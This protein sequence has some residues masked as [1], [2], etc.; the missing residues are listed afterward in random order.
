MIRRDYILRMVEQFM[1][2]LR[3]IQRSKKDQ[4]WDDAGTALDEEFKRLI[5]Q[6]AAGANALSLTELLSRLI[7]GEP[8]QAV[9][10]KTFMLATLLQ[11]AGDLAIANNQ[12]EL[13]RSHYLKGL[14]L[15]LHTLAGGDVEDFPEFVPKVEMFVTALADFELPVET[16]AALMQHYERSGEFAKAEDALFNMLEQADD[17][18]RILEFGMAFYER[19]LVQSDANLEAGNL[20]RPEAESSLSE[21]RSKL[22]L[23]KQ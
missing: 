5:K 18:T 10:M 1:E 15:L 13:G 3:R 2:V 21:L 16:L 12:I 17:N 8:T 20:P 19:L 11:E 22:N 23:L 7:E 14:H 6:G 9:Q 4:R